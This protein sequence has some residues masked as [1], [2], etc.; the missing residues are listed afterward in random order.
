MV[1]WFW[2]TTSAGKKP[3]APFLG[4]VFFNTPLSM[5]VIFLGVRSSTNGSMPSHTASPKCI[6]APDANL[7]N[8]KK[9]EKDKLVVS[10]SVQYRCILSLNKNKEVFLFL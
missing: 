9:K 1:P 10:V 2:F 4:I 7:T 6:P 5:R 8:R 3:L